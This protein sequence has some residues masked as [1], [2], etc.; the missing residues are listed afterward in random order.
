[1]DH[2]A[3]S[4][5]WSVFCAFG[6]AAAMPFRWAMCSS[7]QIVIGLTMYQVDQVPEMMPT[8]IASAKSWMVPTP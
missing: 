7:I 6:V 3:A 5:C 1:M 2:R 8:S 4:A